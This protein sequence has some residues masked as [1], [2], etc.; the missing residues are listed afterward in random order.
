MSQVKEAA[1]SRILE[2]VFV[3]G[4]SLV[5]LG[6]GAPDGSRMRDTVQS[7][8]Q[9]I[10]LAQSDMVRNV[11]KL[12]ANLSRVPVEILGLRRD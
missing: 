10:A 2:G 4:C 3:L 1:M 7:S 9:L 11:A 8:I 12:G 5:G 6:M